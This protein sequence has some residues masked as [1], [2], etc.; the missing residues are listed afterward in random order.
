M[1][2]RRDPHCEPVR[3]D[4]AQPGEDRDL[5]FSLTGCRSR[6]RGDCE[7]QSGPLGA[8]RLGRARRAGRRVGAFAHRM[9]Y[10]PLG[11]VLLGAILMWLGP[12]PHTVRGDQ[13]GD[14]SMAPALAPGQLLIVNRGAFLH[15][16]PQIGEIVTFHPPAGER[17]AG[18]TPRFSGCPF[19][20]RARAVGEGIKRIVA[21]PGDS[22]AVLDGH[23]VR[24]GRRIP[25]PYDRWPCVVARVCDLPRAV[26]LPPGTWW[27]LADN[28]NA[29]NDSRSYGPIPTGWITGL[30]GSP[31]RAKILVAAG[32]VQRNPRR[33]RG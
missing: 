11:C 21:G 19:T 13:L 20:A 15:R 33:A 6:T 2:L 9:R 4:G 32:G 29:P 7:Q 14:D 28:R 18:P 27:L 24:N 25:E 1:S 30:V 3:R 31:T 8:G 17:C 22:V 5:P 26:H 12:Q 10:L 23:L 16:P